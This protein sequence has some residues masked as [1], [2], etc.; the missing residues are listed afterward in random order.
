MGAFSVPPVIGSGIVVPLLVSTPMP[1]GTFSVVIHL[2]L[3]GRGLVNQILDRSQIQ[4][5]QRSQSVHFMRERI[6]VQEHFGDGPE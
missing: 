6:H 4:I 3:K 2:N 5:I 1:S